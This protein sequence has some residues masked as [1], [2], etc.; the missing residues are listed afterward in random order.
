MKLL[1]SLLA[2]FSI[3]VGPKAQ[4]DPTQVVSGEEKPLAPLIMG[5]NDNIGSLQSAIAS[6]REDLYWRAYAVANPTIIRYPGGTVASLWDFANNR[7]YPEEVWSDR[8]GK[9]TIWMSWTANLAKAAASMEDPERLGPEYFQERAHELGAE[10]AWVLNLATDPKDAQPHAAVEFVDR[11]QNAD[12]PVKYIELGNEFEGAS[13]VERWP[14]IDDF[15]EETDP[16]VAAIRKIDP[17]VVLAVPSS[18]PT[19][20]I[21][22]D[23]NNARGDEDRHEKW[24]RQT[25]EREDGIDV[26]NHTYIGVKGAE[27]ALGLKKFVAWVRAEKEEPMLSAEFMVQSPAFM[28]PLAVEHMSGSPK[29]IWQTEYNIWMP[30]G[31]SGGWERYNST[32]ANAL[33]MAN[34][35]LLML[36]NPDKFLM[37]NW[38]SLSGAVFGFITFEDDALAV[39]PAVQLF[40]QLATTV[41]AAT[42]VRALNFPEGPAL[43]GRMIWEGR[44]TPAL[45]GLEFSGDAGPVWVIT[46]SSANPVSVQIGSSAIDP[47]RSFSMS[48]ADPLEAIRKVLPADAVAPIR[49]PLPPQ[50]L[51]VADGLIELP[52]FS[53][54]QIRILSNN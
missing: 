27:S 44:T 18:V 33:Y 10:V 49:E 24:A 1:P 35:Q 42:S 40:S 54:S 21:E 39:S 7:F 17:D 13:F 14:D 50:N 46:N 25:L 36:Q 26:V 43:E 16:I 37:A 51:K 38:H 30:P 47:A 4:A 31:R 19:S 11:L 2:I 15:Q 9:K 22:G 12:I 52:P 6:G 48:A 29:K 34:W 41:R 32:M 28:V 45:I 3:L 23:L 20:P 8:L 5:L 53:Y